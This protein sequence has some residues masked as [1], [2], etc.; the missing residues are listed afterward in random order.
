L[1][2]KRPLNFFTH[3]KVVH[4]KLVSPAVSP[5]YP[6]PYQAH[7][8]LWEGKGEGWKIQ[9]FFFIKTTLVYMLP[10]LELSI[11]TASPKHK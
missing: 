2:S 10:F 11:A 6:K 5:P 3:Y 9:G 4:Y 1:Q 7:D 8:S